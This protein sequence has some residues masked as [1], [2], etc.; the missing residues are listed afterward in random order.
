MTKVLRGLSSYVHQQL[1]KSHLAVK[2]YLNFWSTWL[3]RISTTPLKHRII[4]TLVSAPWPEVDFSPQLVHVTAQTSIKII[5]HVGEFDMVALFSKELRYEPEVFG[6]IETRIDNYDA[7]VEIGAN[8]GIFTVFIASLLRANG[9]QA[10]I[11]SFEPSR[12]AFYRLLQNVQIN[13]HDNV[14]LFNCAVGQ[15]SEPIDFFEPEGHLTN[16]SINEAFAGLFSATVKSNKV[17]SVNGDFVAKLVKDHQKLLIK[18]D[19]EGAENLVLNTL[20]NIIQEK[21]PDLII[22]VLSIQE[23]ALNEI[24]FLRNEYELYNIADK[25][26]IPQTLFVAHPHHRDYLLMPKSR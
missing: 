20:K 5:P 10:D 18:I 7:V 22:E 8:V 12:K 19:V 4:N 24:T 15:E 9:K 17:I 2:L 11:F 13:K 23:D 25:R 14:L 26:L 1:S 21:K 6:I 16:G 3:R